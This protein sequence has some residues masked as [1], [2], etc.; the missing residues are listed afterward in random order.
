MEENSNSQP[1]HRIIYAHIAYNGIEFSYGPN[2][3]ASVC[4]QVFCCVCAHTHT[5]RNVEV[6]G[7]VCDMYV[8]V[9]QNERFPVCR[10][11]ERKQCQYL[12]YN[13]KRFLRE[14]DLCDH[15]IVKRKIH[16]LAR[17]QYNI[18]YIQTYTIYVNDTEFDSLSDKTKIYS[19]PICLRRRK[20]ERE[21]VALFRRE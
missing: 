19:F 21:R 17:I 16:A 11:I 13:F 4:V 8:Y 18:L 15:W 20:R 2:A 5:E 9:C 6:R 10:L 1:T 7:E 12:K 14:C 3:N